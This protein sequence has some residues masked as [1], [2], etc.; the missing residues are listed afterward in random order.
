M[1]LHF[2]L[3]VLSEYWCWKTEQLKVQWVTSR[4]QCWLAANLWYQPL[5]SLISSAFQPISIQLIFQWYST[6][7]LGKPLNAD[8]LKFRAD[9]RTMHDVTT[10][11]TKTCPW[12][13]QAMVEAVLRDRNMHGCTFFF[14]LSMAAGN[15][16]YWG[17]LVRN[18]PFPLIEGDIKMWRKSDRK[19]INVVKCFLLQCLFAFYNKYIVRFDRFDPEPLP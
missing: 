16:H 13:H 11:A 14:I 17:F 7:P 10:C 4:T 9:Q 6:L 8:L 5:F 19:E 18:V 3:K 2:L 12:S 15:Q 1:N